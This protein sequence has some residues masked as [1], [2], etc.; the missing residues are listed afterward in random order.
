MGD[1]RAGGRNCSDERIGGALGCMA[2][3]TQIIPVGARCR[4]LTVTALVTD[5]LCGGS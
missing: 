1:Q 3:A 2:G 5:P 4:G